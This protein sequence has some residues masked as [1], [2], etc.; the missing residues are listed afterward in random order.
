MTCQ[1]LNSVMLLNVN[2]DLAKDC[3]LKNAM[4]EFVTRNDVR[5]DTFGLPWVSEVWCERGKVDFDDN[6][7]ACCIINNEK[8]V[9]SK[10]IET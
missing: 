6:K 9:S 10:H 7:L 8:L 1:R 5:K 3:S 2:R 4:H